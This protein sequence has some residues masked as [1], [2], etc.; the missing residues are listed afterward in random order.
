MNLT[1][2]QG[3]SSIMFRNKTL[4]PRVSHATYLGTILSDTIDNMLELNNRIADCMCTANRLG[5]FW[6]K[7]KN[8][9]QWKIRVFDAIMKSKLLSGLGTIQ[10]K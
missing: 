9:T 6:N 7:A 2:N 4:V 1:A 10:L 3:V 5:A 8:T